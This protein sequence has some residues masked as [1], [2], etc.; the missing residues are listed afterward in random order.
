MSLFSMIC[1][2]RQHV[3]ATSQFETKFCHKSRKPMV[4]SYLG[5]VRTIRRGRM[6][7]CRSPRDRLREVQRNELVLVGTP[8]NRTREIASQKNTGS[9]ESNAC[10]QRNRA[11]DHA[12]QNDVNQQIRNVVLLV[13]VRIFVPRNA[14]FVVHRAEK[15]LRVALGKRPSRDCHDWSGALVKKRTDVFHSLDTRLRLS[16]MMRRINAPQ[17]F[18]G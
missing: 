18:G 9:S 6:S 10:R 8:K 5:T 15:C 3:G 14:G 11:D 7:A 2:I 17:M 12:Q 4:L 16:G 1:V 13:E